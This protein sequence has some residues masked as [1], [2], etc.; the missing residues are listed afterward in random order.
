[1]FAKF[2]CARRDKE[3]NYTTEIMDDDTIAWVASVLE[4]YCPSVQ[5]M[6][7]ACTYAKLLC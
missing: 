2:L 1:M 7:R 3:C 5:S 4:L 6:E